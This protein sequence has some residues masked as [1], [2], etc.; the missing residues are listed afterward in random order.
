MIQ[1]NR[2]QP[3]G[4]IAWLGLALLALL[5]S[6][7]ASWLILIPSD[8]AYEWLYSLIG[9][10]QHIA[11]YAPKNPI[12]LDFESTT[13]IERFRLFSG[14]VT[15][16]HQQGVGLDALVY[17]NAEGTALAKLLS[18][19]EVVHLQDVAILIDRMKVLLLIC[20]ALFVGLLAWI[21]FKEVRLPTFKSLL[22]TMLAFL[23]LVIIVVLIIGPYEVFYNLHVWV[24]PD[25]H[26]W[27]FYYEESLM[28]TMMKAPDL[29]AYIAILLLVIAVPVFV[30]IMW[31]IR[32]IVMLNTPRSHAA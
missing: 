12:K 22:L 19:D 5:L 6:F 17:H 30:L 29:F 28:S 32:R 16:I 10:D 15:A 24:F 23:G 4:N 1:S 21:Y 25:E 31:I 18:H 2:Q 20:T 3:A 13:D 11:T 7:G 8:F 9:I 26:K 27:F 14:I